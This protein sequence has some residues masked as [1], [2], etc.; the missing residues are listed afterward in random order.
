[1]AEQRPLSVTLENRLMGQGIYVTDWER[2]EGA[3]ELE[4]ETVASTETVTSDEV[5]QV[6]RTLLAAVDERG[7]WTP[8]RLEATSR[9]T[10]GMVR[11][12]WHVEAA[13]FEALHDRIDEVAFSRRVLST[14]DAP[15]GT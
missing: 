10:D 15:H 4:Y 3:I 13:W 8:R 5:G 2:T 1:M 6:L 9:T 7:G 14:V 11:G 12:T